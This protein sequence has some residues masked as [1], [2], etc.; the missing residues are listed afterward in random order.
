MRR[1][2]KAA[3]IFPVRVYVCVCAYTHPTQPHLYMQACGLNK[4]TDICSV[5]VI[6]S[7]TLLINMVSPWQ[8]VSLLLLTSDVQTSQFLLCSFSLSFFWMPLAFMA[9][10]SS[11]LL[12]FCVRVFVG[13]LMWSEKEVQHWFI[14][15]SPS[16]KPNLFPV[17]SC[18]DRMENVA[19][20][21][22]HHNHVIANLRL[23]HEL[24][25]VFLIP[26]S[27]FG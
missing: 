13:F 20:R 3:Q 22:S 12:L 1:K 19:G 26:V 16:H 9:A 5:K 2:K 11:L 21:C 23:E 27:S 7:T 15:W 10:D 24:L 18:W 4:Q 25:V 6:Y 8:W 17:C 14:D